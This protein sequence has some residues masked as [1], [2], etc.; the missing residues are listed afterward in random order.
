MNG[1]SKLAREGFSVRFFAGKLAPTMQ[2]IFV[3]K[4][5]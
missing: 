1:R 4:L 2:H 3:P 5:G